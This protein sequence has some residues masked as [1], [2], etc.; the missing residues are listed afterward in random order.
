M[1]GSFYSFKEIVT[2]LMAERKE[3]DGRV[4]EKMWAVLG[5]FL[6]FTDSV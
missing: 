4:K 2:D 5:D 6:T 1:P 3:G